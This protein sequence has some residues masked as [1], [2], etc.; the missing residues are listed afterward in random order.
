MLT[1]LRELLDSNPHRQ[2]RRGGD[3]RLLAA[4]GTM[5]NNGTKSTPALSGDLLGD[6]REEL[7]LRYDR[8]QRATH[9]HHDECRDE[10][11]LPPLPIRSTRGD[12]LAEHRR[13]T[14]RRIRSFFI[15]SGMSTPPTSNI[16]LAVNAAGSAAGYADV[17]ARDR[18]S[19][20]A[21]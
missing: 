10:L 2:V 19:A 16:V 6:W 1:P 15:G 9:L 4:D 18:H 11:H 17:P 20:V 3:T 7:V 8:Q 21:L 13:T 14:S 5:S 12:R